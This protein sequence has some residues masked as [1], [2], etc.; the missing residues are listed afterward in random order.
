MSGRR[1]LWWTACAAIAAA[2]IAIFLRHPSPPK[3]APAPA[4]ATG[5]TGG[6]L[7]D[8]VAPKN[9]TPADPDLSGPAPT[10][11]QL[12]KQ[13]ALIHE[14]QE[15]VNEL[16]FRST[17]AMQAHNGD[18]VQA[19]AG[20]GK[21]LVNL[22]NLRLSALQA[23]LEAARRARPH[24]PTV[25]WLTGEL[26]LVAGGEP[27]EI[28]PYFE[29]ALAAGVKQPQL[30]TSMAMVEFDSNHFEAAYEYARKALAADPASQAVWDAFVRASFA[31]E[32]FREAVDRLDRAFPKVKPPWAI[33]MRREAEALLQQWNRELALRQAEEKRGDLP[34]VRLTIEHRAFSGQTEKS[35]GRGDVEIELF[36]DQAPRTVAIFLSRVEHGLYDGTRFN[37]A[38]AGRMVMGGDLPGSGEDVPNESGSAA[39]RGHFRGSISMRP[40]GQF[41]MMLTPAPD[42]NGRVT[43]F[44]RVLKGQDVVDQVTRG[45]TSREIGDFGKI[46][47]GD[48][49]VHAEVVRGGRM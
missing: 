49:L 1:I 2:G 42:F 27:E 9:G 47:P 44:G 33:L 34:I 35:T 15:Q 3:V 13:I 41:L 22:L 5:R 31:T 37:L 36:K 12:E 48:I 17:A 45:R 10:T 30:F 39:A 14:N 8:E 28:R 11:A 32:R 16:K 7:L 43:A 46:I 40:G 4:A 38:E 19:L 29:H 24:D 23:D 26:L 18:L 6:S 20:Q 25:Q 21:Q